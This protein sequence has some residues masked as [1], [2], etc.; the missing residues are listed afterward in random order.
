M[1]G[2]MNVKFHNMVWVGPWDGSYYR[3]CLYRLP[4]E[5]SLIT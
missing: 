5:N 3:C 2:S 1:H 4:A